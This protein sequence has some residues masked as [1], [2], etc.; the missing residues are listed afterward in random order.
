[1]IGKRNKIIQISLLLI[2]KI[3]CPGFILVASL[4]A[5]D[6][7]SN[8]NVGLSLELPANG[9]EPVTTALNK[10][11]QQLET[12]RQEFGGIE[13]MP[14]VRFFLFGMGNRPKLLY[15]NGELRYA[16]HEEVI[17]KWAFKTEIIIP[18]QYLVELLTAASERITIFENEKG[19]FISETG[20]IELLFGSDSEIRLPSFKDSRYNEILKVLHQEILVNVYEGQPLPNY[21]VY[22]NAWRRDAA[23]MAMCLKKT[24]NLPLIEDW[25]L[26]LDEPY[27]GNNKSA[28]I[29]ETE[30]DNLGQTLY[31]I[32][33]FSDKSHPL[34]AKIL[35][36]VKKYEVKDEQGFYIRGRSDFHYTP[37]YQTKWL[38]FGLKSLD[39]NDP[40]TV[41][42]VQDDYSALFWWDFKENYMKGTVDAYDDWENPYYYPYIGWATDHFHALKR[43]PISNRD[44]PL[45]WEINASQA[46]YNQMKVVDDIYAREK[47]A[48]P[49]TWHAAEIFLYLLDDKMK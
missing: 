15:K 46:D 16:L 34:V 5:L 26:H 12:F 38:K 32:S 14:D 43:G 33:L 17:R 9:S 27:D 18:N 7:P 41:P 40:Y 44:Y 42:S 1:M 28:G 2:F 6:K 10:Y 11:H 23:M 22:R 48:S 36:E 39:L 20:K 31:L 13:N 3:I 19:I 37:V 35:E 4:S 45:T 21:F 24:G 29:A 8:R 49:H 25:V 47:I 30:A